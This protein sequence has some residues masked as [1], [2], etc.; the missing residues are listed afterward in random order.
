MSSSVPDAL[1]LM[2]ESDNYPRL[3][4]EAGAVGAALE[5]EVLE[6][7]SARDYEELR[8][9]LWRIRAA[10]DATPCVTESPPIVPTSSRA[11]PAPLAPEAPPTLSPSTVSTLC[12]RPL[13]R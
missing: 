6:R 9:A 7:A 1:P 12:E 8:L 2:L 4:N 13:N 3:G 5:K 11:S 10:S